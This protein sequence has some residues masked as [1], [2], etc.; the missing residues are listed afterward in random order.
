MAGSWFSSFLW[1]IWSVEFADRNLGGAAEKHLGNW[2]NHSE[3]LKKG[4]AKK[5]HDG[6]DSRYGSLPDD[7]ESR[8]LQYSADYG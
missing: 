3:W 6:Y 7:I 2:V 5:E 8:I 1:S 4:L